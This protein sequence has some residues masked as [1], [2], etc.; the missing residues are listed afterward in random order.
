MTEARHSR[1]P[2]YEESV[3]NIVGFVSTKEFLLNPDGELRELLKP[4]A[5]F[6]EGARLHRVFRHMQK[7]RLNMSVIVNEYGETA[8]I[9]TVE[10]M[11]EEIVGEI[12]DEYEKAEELIREVG[13]NQWLVM[14]RA[15][16]EHVNATCGLSLPESESIT[17]NGYL[18]DQFGEIPGPGRVLEQDGASF[19]IVESVRR[20]VVSCR[21]ERKAEEMAATDE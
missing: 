15:P 10:D 1:I 20:R 12:Y 13:P 18:T 16:V 2:V 5:I 4:V 14:A 21:V 17:L 19:T 7:Q 6:P 8:G 9:I 3:D 11:M